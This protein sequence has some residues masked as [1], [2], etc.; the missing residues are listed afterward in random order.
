MKWIALDLGRNEIKAAVRDVRRRPTKLMYNHHGRLYSYMPSEGFISDEGYAY[1]GNDVPL[2]G[3]LYPEKLFDVRDSVNGDTLLNALYGTIMD[4][5]SRHYNDISVGVVLL[6]EGYK[7]E[8]PAINICKNFYPIAK[9]H[10]KDVKVKYSSE[11]LTSVLFDNI[12]TTMIIDI[13]MSSLKLSIVENGVQSAYF[14][15]KELGFSTVD[16]SGIIG[17]TFNKDLSE[18]EWYL[19]GQLLEKVKIDICQGEIDASL[20]KV[21]DLDSHDEQIIVKKFEDCMTRYLYRCF[22]M[23]TRNIKYLFKDWDNI[24]NIVLCGGASNYYKMKDCFCGYMRGYGT[25]LDSHNVIIYEKDA[26]WAAVFNALNLPDLIDFI[27][28][29]D[30]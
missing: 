19:H 16:I 9:S 15:S 18:V 10:F 5:A 3:A 17:Y 28:V 11:V 25:D 2:V 27:Y 30:N 29:F 14:E 8:D 21:L 1:V 4:A 6:C 13:S 12:G 20:L 22:E 7:N 26:Q 24:K 23:C